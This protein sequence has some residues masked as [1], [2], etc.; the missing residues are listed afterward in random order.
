MVKD[1]WNREIR[2]GDFVV[3]ASKSSDEVQMGVMANVKKKTRVK[4]YKNSY[5]KKWEAALRPYA[6]YTLERTLVI[7]DEMIV[8]NEPELF[9]VMVEVRKNL[10][11]P[12]NVGVASLDALRKMLEQDMAA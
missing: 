6:M 8:D 9:K 4:V 5:T 12:T 10:R 2:N 7:P 11:L 1:I 3:S